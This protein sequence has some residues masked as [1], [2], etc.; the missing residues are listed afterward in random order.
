M[1]LKRVFIYVAFAFGLAWIWWFATVYPAFNSASG[2]GQMAQLL[3]AAGMFA[4]ALAVVL[5]RLV[6]RE[7][8][9]DAWIVPKNFRRTWKYYVLAWF[10][11]M[12]LVALGA[13]LYYVVF[14]GDFDVSMSALVESSR[15][16]AIDAGQG[17]AIAGVD[18]ETLR[19]ALM[20]Q[21]A[22]IPL[23]PL[24]N[25]VTC[26]G[27]EWGWRGYLLP[28]LSARLSIAATLLVSGVIW[29]LWH[30]P[31]TVL[32]H[33]Y[34]MGY[35]GYP[36]AGIAAMCLF[37]TVLGVFFSYVTL[38]SGSCLPAVFGHG[39]VNG[40]AAAGIMFSASG[41]NPF[42]GP[43][44]TGIVGGVFFIIAAIVMAYALVKRERAALSQFADGVAPASSAPVAP[45]AGPVPPSALV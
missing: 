1:E 5:T 25:A 10:G 35:A 30:A 33:N 8:F 44:P 27:E 38:R 32:G 34:G 24:L 36:F 40:C 26:F 37:T 45:A 42:V 16:A 43:A 19:L 31:I 28:K 17:E 39:M 18:D 11:P 13:V 29:G 12:V 15:Q 2:F 41:G 20:T 22:V 4:P 23:A 21:L 9:K 14:P 3:V 6:T 7:G